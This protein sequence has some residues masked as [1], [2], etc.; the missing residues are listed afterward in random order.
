MKKII[1]ILP[2]HLPLL[3]GSLERKIGLAIDAARK[4][5]VASIGAKISATFVP[6]DYFLGGY[7]HEIKSFSQKTIT[8]S[9]AEVK[10]AEAQVNEGLD[11]VYD[12]FR[13]ID[14]RSAEFLGQIAYSEFSADLVESFQEKNGFY[15]YVSKI[16]DHL[17]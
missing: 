6:H 10:F 16:L 4:E 2:K 15:V 13:Q 11:V 14:E 9:A 1:Q 8:I 17:S 3:W 7:Y 12:I 5:E